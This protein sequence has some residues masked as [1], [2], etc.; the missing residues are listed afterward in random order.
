MVYIMMGVSGCGKTTIGQLL[1]D[2]LNIP[3]Y[4]ADHFHPQ[5]NIDK[6][7]SG[8]PLN[9][10]DRKPWLNILSDRIT[11]WN[12]SGGAVLACSALKQVYRDLLEKN[13]DNNLTFIYLKGTK[14][15]IY[16]RIKN[17]D[18]HYMPPELLDS[19][20]QDLEEPK[21]SIKVN[22]DQKPVFILDEILNRLSK[23]S[24]MNH[25]NFH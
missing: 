12:R 23:S 16:D 9:D 18:G 1:A 14:E 7:S 2:R 11:E 24:K 22:I 8:I 6:M 17:R 3:F 10:E 21:N 19:Q 25:Q 13:N 4:D 15:M 5:S 20:F